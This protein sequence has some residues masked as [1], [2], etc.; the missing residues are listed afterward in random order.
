MPILIKDLKFL[1]D[2]EARHHK[3][4][5]REVRTIEEEEQALENYRSMKAH[6]FPESQYISK[7]L[8]SFVPF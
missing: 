7:D 4:C 3:L 2:L 6:I 5:V 1:V 8:Q